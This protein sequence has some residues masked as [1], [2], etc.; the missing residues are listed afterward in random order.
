ML[1]KYRTLRYVCISHSV[2]VCVCFVGPH[3][4]A[5]TCNVIGYNSDGHDTYVNTY[6]I[7]QQHYT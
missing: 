3:S 5:N 1:H 7:L 6:Q 4:H 2:Y